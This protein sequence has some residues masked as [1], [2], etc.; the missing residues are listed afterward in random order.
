[1]GIIEE[2]CI[3]NL[4]KDFR[5]W[6][7]TLKANVYFMQ[8]VV[9]AFCFDQHCTYVYVNKFD[10]GYY[11]IYHRIFIDFFSFQRIEFF[12]WFRW[13]CSILM[14]SLNSLKWSETG[15]VAPTAYGLYTNFEICIFIKSED[16]P[17]EWCWEWREY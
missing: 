5:N 12:M 6:V 13:P 2:M 11:Y 17:F 8:V 10:Y 7:W 14:L 16:T 4:S 1:M 9:S 3:S 15:P